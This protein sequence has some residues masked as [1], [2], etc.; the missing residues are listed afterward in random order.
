MYDIK[1]GEKTTVTVSDGDVPTAGFATYSIDKDGVY[2]FSTYTATTAK[3]ADGAHAVTNAVTK[4]G[5]LLTEGSSLVDIEAKDA[6]I[7]N[8]T[9]NSD[10]DSLSLSDIAKAGTLTAVAYV[11][12]EV[13]TCIVVN[14]YAA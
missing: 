9:G 7:I 14:T 10:N 4:Y 5:T 12:D 2:T 13:V 8:N 3:N 6:V 11:D 1:T